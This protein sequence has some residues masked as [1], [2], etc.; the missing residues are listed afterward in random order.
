MWIAC[1]VHVRFLYHWSKSLHCAYIFILTAWPRSV[2]LDQWFPTFLRPWPDFRF[3]NVRVSPLNLLDKKQAR[4]FR[5]ALL[6][7]CLYIK[8]KRPPGRKPLFLLLW[9]LKCKCVAV[10][11]FAE[12]LLRDNCGRMPVFGTFV[13][14]FTRS[15]R[16]APPEGSHRVRLPKNRVQEVERPF[17]AAE[18]ENSDQHQP[19]YGDNFRIRLHELPQSCHY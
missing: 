7:H 13:I 19:R 4:H 2:L 15:H 16:I 12:R 14:T 18:E 11:F 8:D 3:E 9:Q 17:V 10:W 1:R 6:D 5:Q